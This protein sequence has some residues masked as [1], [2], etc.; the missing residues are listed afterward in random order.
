MVIDI[1]THFLSSASFLSCC[2]NLF[3]LFY[4]FNAP[5]TTEIYTLSLHDALPILWTIGHWTC[6]QSVVLDTLGSVDIDVLVDVRRLPGSRRSPQFDADE[7]ASWLGE[8]G[9]EY[10]HLTELAEIG[11]AHV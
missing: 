9:I 3:L 10:L 2:S 11:R 8:A 7:M 5:A 1:L 6:P 4:F